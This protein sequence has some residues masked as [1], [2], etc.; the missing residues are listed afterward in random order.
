[1]IISGLLDLIY[2]LVTTVLSVINL[3]DIPE[4]GKGYITQFQ[5]IISDGINLLGTYID[6]SYIKV[7]LTIFITIILAEELYHLVMWI[8]KKIP[9]LNIK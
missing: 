7:L 2:N 3:P 5:E 1:M 8:I 6:F 4:A 9:L